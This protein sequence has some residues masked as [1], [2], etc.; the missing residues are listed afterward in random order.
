[1]RTRRLS[2]ART[3]AMACLAMPMAAMM[4]P[5][6]AA[7]E[8]ATRS[9]GAEFAAPVCLLDV[10]TASKFEFCTGTLVRVDPETRKGFI[11]T[12]AH[13]LV[14][15]GTPRAVAISF[16]PNPVRDRQ[17]IPADGFHCHPDYD[18]KARTGPDLALVEFTL[19]EGF[20]VEPMLLA[21]EKKLD[22]YR[23]RDILAV[24]GY[25]SYVPAGAES[26]SKAGPAAWDTHTASGRVRRM[27]Y[28]P[29][30]FRPANQAMLEQDSYEVTHQ[31]LGSGDRAA[32]AGS[33]PFRFKPSNHWLFEFKDLAWE[34]LPVGGDSGAP[35]FHLDLEAG[36][37]RLVAVFKANSLHPTRNEETSVATALT[38]GL[39]RWIDKTTPEAMARLEWEA[40]NGQTI[41]SIYD[42]VF[43]S[44]AAGK[45][46]PGA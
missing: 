39:L 17:R 26:E 31:L 16:A 18:G 22:H 42:S 29:M 5:G 25:G 8:E 23:E 10:L 19:P 32:V 9:L 20:A 40:R 38:P 3:L 24:A 11:L 44:G 36:R 14:R 35:L 21:E 13:C 37:N 2:L 30:G 28:L 1:M 4:V 12:T 6:G 33:R 27:G 43:K 15:Y 7:G 45:G 41:Q 46:I 34:V